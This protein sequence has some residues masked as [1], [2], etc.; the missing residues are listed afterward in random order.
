MSARKKMAATQVTDVT[1]SYMSPH[2]TR[3]T[4]SPRVVTPMTCAASPSALSTRAARTQ[5][6]V[7][8][9]EPR[10]R[11]P[12]PAEAGSRSAYPVGPGP[13]PA[14]PD[15]DP[16]P[17]DSDPADSDPGP[18]DPDPADSSPAAADPDPAPTLAAGTPAATNSGTSAA[19]VSPLD[20]CRP[21]AK[22]PA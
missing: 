22:S 12:W 19:G 10:L 16:G 8:S 21:K 9:Q 4:A 20:G 2:G 11:P 6:P 3:C 17:A 1:N 5:D 14:D 18:A 7:G 15:P 13:D